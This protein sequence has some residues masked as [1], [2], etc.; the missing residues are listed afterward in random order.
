M[1]ENKVQ[2]TIEALNKAQEGLSEAKKSLKDLGDASEKGAKQSNTAWASLKGTFAELQ[3]NFLMLSGAFAS[4]LFIR[5]LIQIGAQAQ[6]VESAFKELTKSAGISGDALISKMSKAAAATVDDSDIMQKAIKG[7]TQGLS[8]GDL[9]QIM[10]MARVTARTQGIDVKDAY[11]RIT[12]AIANELPRGLRQFGLVTKEQMSILNKA[13]AA[14]VEDVDLLSLAYA[15][16]QV[17][18]A[19][20]GPVAKT[21]SEELQK[22]RAVINDF[23]EKTGGLMVDALTKAVGKLIEFGNAMKA[24]QKAKMYREFAE[25]EP[26]PT[27]K[28]AL[29][30]IAREADRPEIARAPVVLSKETAAA[31]LK[32][33]E[34]RIKAQTAAAEAAKKHAQEL[35]QL[36]KE[37]EKWKEQVDNLNPSLDENAKKMNDIGTATDKFIKGGI[38]KDAVKEWKTRAEFFVQMA[39]RMKNQEE[40][41]EKDRKYNQTRVE[42]AKQYE[43]QITVYLADELQKRL[44]A[45]QEKAKKL[46]ELASKGGAD[47]E[48]EDA[49][50]TARMKKNQAQI[51]AEFSQRADQAR[52]EA[53]ISEVDRAQK[54]FQLEPSE[55]VQQKLTLTKQLLQSQED[56]L[57]TLSETA[58]TTAW[59]TQADAIEQTRNKFTELNVEAEKYTRTYGEGWA[60][61]VKAYQ[62][63]METAFESGEALAK[64]TA[65][66]METAFG[67]FLDTTSAG[68]LDFGKLATQVLADIQ[69][70]LLR[71][72]VVKPLV[73][74]ITGGGGGGGGL[75]GL[76]GLIGSFLGGGTG[77]PMNAPGVNNSLSGWG[78]GNLAETAFHQGGRVVK[79]HIGGF[80]S[81]K[82]NEVLSV[83]EDEEFVIRKEAARKL[84]PAMLNLVNQ[85]QVPASPA[86]PGNMTISVPVAITGARISNRDI[87]ALRGAI[88][89]V[90]DGWA[91]KVM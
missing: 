12:D 58:D 81:L 1:P 74:A 6:Q 83:L 89:D 29:L 56:Y 25:E 9:V 30:K 24:Y 34:D 46:R 43:E 2:I 19:Q 13:I 37:F 70:E 69:R 33:E 49:K 5:H 48:A 65:E 59:R 53:Q 42:A 79:L 17:K 35:E 64:K 21:A 77:N 39:E 86:Q 57:G 32:A 80:P 4:T 27:K 71:T 60:R 44:L 23:A 47:Y 50:I 15:N 20:M 28:A 62:R 52:I 85:G 10:E 61:G 87:S 7:M 14:G 18:L 78:A 26:D 82:S 3:Q 16:L 63:S 51:R 36:R 73:G 72:L 75:A 41:D 22:L 31:Q 66:S 90:C 91:R 68:F 88:E 55:A 40:Y 54:L 84:G 8:G 11:E 76:L 67:N 38:S 45:E